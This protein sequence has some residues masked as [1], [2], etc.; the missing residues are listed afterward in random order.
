MRIFLH[1]R[2]NYGHVTRY[3][4][5]CNHICLRSP[6]GNSSR[7]C[8]T[9]LSNTT[10]THLCLTVNSFPRSRLFANI[11]VFDLLKSRLYLLLICS[12]YDIMIGLNATRV[13]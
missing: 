10:Q 12:S 2:I 1:K 11:N 13:F 6:S 7:S 5:A 8:S 9:C 3:A 4:Y